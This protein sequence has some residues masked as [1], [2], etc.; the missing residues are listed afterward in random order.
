MIDANILAGFIVTCVLLDL[1]PGPDNLYVLAQ[2]ISSGFKAGF[3]VILGL[4]T[5]LV[6]HTFAVV[7]GIAA[8]VQSSLLAFTVLKYLGA[9]YLIYLAWQA[10]RSGK[11]QISTG[12][13]NGQPLFALYRRGILM[14]ISNPKL[15]VFF[16]AFLPQFANPEQGSV[17]LQLA[18]LG[19]IF[20]VLALMVFSAI[21]LLA[22]RLGRYL[23]DSPQMMAWLNRVT[24]VVF[25]G[26]A[27]RLAVAER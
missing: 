14:S 27:F 20:I 13:G 15:L 3:A 19:G 9:A 26:L 22:D 24:G 6:V 23:G 1:A 25:V 17:A 2:S 12:P 10:F 18:T 7:V 8:L 5:G 11:Q 21:S 16:L 4:C